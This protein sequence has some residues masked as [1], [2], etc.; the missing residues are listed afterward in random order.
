M[1]W[2]DGYISR[3]NQDWIRPISAWPGGYVYL[4]AAVASRRVLTHKVAVRLEA[5]HAH[6]VLEQA[7][8]RFGVPEIVN[9]DQGSQFT[10]EDFTQAVLSRSCRLSMDSKGAWHDKVFV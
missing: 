9:T 1:G 2:P 5:C 10:A 4:T 7:F 3:A 8:A 6:A